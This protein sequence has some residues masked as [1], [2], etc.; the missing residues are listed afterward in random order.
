MIT[1]PNKGSIAKNSNKLNDK[2]PDYKG[3]ALVGGVAY[4]IS[5]WINEKDDV[6]YLSLSF[7]PQDE[8]MRNDPKLTKPPMIKNDDSI[9]F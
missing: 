6:K 3:S 8:A 5:G 1:K 2:H 7:T 9:P 4:W